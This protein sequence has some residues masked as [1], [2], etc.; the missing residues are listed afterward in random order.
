MPGIPYRDR[1]PVLSGAYIAVDLVFDELIALVLPLTSL[2]RKIGTARR[3][4]EAN[5]GNGPTVLSRVIAGEDV[6]VPLSSS[7]EVSTDLE[8]AQQQHR[9][10]ERREHLRW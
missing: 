8:M 7:E 5:G 9:F 3:V 1:R 10:I 2:G 6:V 4:V